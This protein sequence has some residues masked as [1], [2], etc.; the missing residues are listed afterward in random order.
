M[1]DQVNQP[2]GFRSGISLLML[3]RSHLYTSSKNDI[4]Y[5]AFA[6]EFSFQIALILHR[7]LLPSAVC[8]CIQ[9]ELS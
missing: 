7:S 4:S 6:W 8:V 2:G 1:S 9:K 3:C 5:G